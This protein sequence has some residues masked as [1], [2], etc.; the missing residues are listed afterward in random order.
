VL[1]LGFAMRMYLKDSGWPVCRLYV[2]A[3]LL[4]TVRTCIVLLVFTFL[5]VLVLLLKVAQASK[6]FNGCRNR[7]AG[8]SFR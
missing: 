8:H 4:A 3:R 1:L 6:C 5:L 7:V 2:S